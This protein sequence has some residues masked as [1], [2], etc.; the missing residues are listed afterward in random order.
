MMLMDDTSAAGTFAFE[1]VLNAAL[2]NLC[3]IQ[4]AVCQFLLPGGGVVRLESLFHLNYSLFDN[5]G[6]TVYRIQHCASR[7]HSSNIIQSPV[8]ERL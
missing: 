4:L 3:C 5:Y 6:S 7:R 1:F 8:T 2:Y